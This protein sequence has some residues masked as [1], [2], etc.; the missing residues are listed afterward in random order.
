M[1]RNCYCSLRHKAE[2]SLDVNGVDQLTQ[3]SVDDG[4][5]FCCSQKKYTYS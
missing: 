4:Y 2:L 3:A 5:L 1:R